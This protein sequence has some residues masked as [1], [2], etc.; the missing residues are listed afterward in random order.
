MYP[1]SIHQTSL[2][3]VEQLSRNY[4][5]FMFSIIKQNMKQ[6]EVVQERLGESVRMM[7]PWTS[8]VRT[9][10]ADDSPCQKQEEIEELREQVEQLTQKIARLEN[11]SRSNS[12]NRSGKGHFK[13]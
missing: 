5:N 4:T 9:Q 7:A 3:V 8:G 1:T 11:N 13:L 2:K 12:W 6:S 10:T